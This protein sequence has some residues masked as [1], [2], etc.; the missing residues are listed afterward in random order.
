MRA[1]L[2]KHKQAIFL[3]GLVGTALLVGCGDS[4]TTTIT[5]SNL[6]TGDT[7]SSLS[8]DISKFNS[9]TI[10]PIT[11][12]DCTL[13][14]G[15]SSTCYKVTIK[16]FPSDRDEV[17]PFCPTTTS[18]DAEST[19]KWFDNGVLYDLTGDFV[20]NLATFYGD[21]SWKLYNSTT[22]AIN[23]TTT[24]TAC[25]AAARPNVAA[26]YNNF[27]VECDLSYYSTVEGEGVSSTYLIPKTP[28]PRTNASS[29]GNDGVGVALNGVKLEA[30]AP[31]EAILSAYTIAALDDCVGHINPYEGYHY[32]GA[33]HGEGTC[34]EVPFEEDGHGGIFAYALDGYAIYGML[35][36]NGEEMTDLDSCRG[37]TDDTR[38]YH[39]H[40]AGAGENAFIG[41]FTGEIAE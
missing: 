16:G 24:Q 40:T 23:V 13:S 31:T 28:V 27:C 22:G 9:T 18:T 8:V 19:G 41:C 7:N 3:S 11:E 12:V 2:T 37:H 1:Y 10:S 4:N 33:N 36:N 38:G 29:I 17:G 20:S 34:P 14:N 5:D 26:E 21:S 35:N 15:A 6:T 39:Y 30:A 32:H 25:E